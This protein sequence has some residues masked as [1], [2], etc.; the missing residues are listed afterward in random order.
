MGNDRDWKILG[1]EIVF[2]AEPYVKVAKQ[3]VETDSGV[4]VDDFYQVILRSFVCCVAQLTNGKFL[5]IRQYKHGLGRTSLTFPA[6]FLEE[7]EDPTEG[8]LRE[9][10]E[11]TGLVPKTTQGFGTFVDNGNQRGAM[12]HF[13][14]AQGCEQ[15]AEPCSGD[16]ETMVYEELTK[17]EVDGALAKGEIGLSHHALAWLLASRRL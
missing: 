3:T 10:K 15:V 17:D 7:G 9:L 1:Q 16:L 6:G 5:M 8:A 2:S 11:E 13:F 14:L 4:V 12:G